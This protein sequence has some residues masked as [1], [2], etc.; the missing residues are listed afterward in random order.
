VNRAILMGPTNR[1]L[2]DWY[3][4]FAAADLVIGYNPKSR[5]KDHFEQARHAKLP[6]YDVLAKAG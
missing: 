1:D 4:T 2:V 5:F 3:L 6:W